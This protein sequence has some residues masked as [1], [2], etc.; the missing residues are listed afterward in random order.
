MLRLLMAIFGVGKL[1]PFAT[2]AALEAEL[3]TLQM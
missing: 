2:K 3:P 1:V